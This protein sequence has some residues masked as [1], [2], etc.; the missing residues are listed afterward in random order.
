MNKRSPGFSGEPYRP[1]PARYWRRLSGDRLQCELCPH[2]CFLRPGESG[3]CAI[4]RNDD[5]ELN[6]YSY[7][8]ISSAAYD[9]I[10]KKPLFHFRPGSRIF[11]IGSVG[12]NLNCDFCQNWRIARHL[13]N[14]QYTDTE[15]LLD[16]AARHNSVGIAY[17][18]NEP[19]INYEFIA[20]LAPLV[21]QRGLAN[22]LVT[23]GFINPEPLNE[24]LPHIDALN[25]DLK[26]FDDAV[27]RKICGGRLEPVLETI[28]TAVP[29]AHVEVTCLLIPGVN[30]EPEQITALA[31]ALAEISPDIPLHLSRYFPAY[32]STRPPTPI[33]TVLAAAGSARHYLRHVH[34]GNI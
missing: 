25:I 14:G 9:P 21:H 24:L 8:R 23:N 5:G 31:E 16:L 4:R 6:T 3:R 7:A 27:Y 29:L 30:T 18:Y 22:V 28:R 10:E 13:D 15:T 33:P 19:L 32:R 26:V 1:H 2:Y 17:T 34:A 11:S 12:C 20:D